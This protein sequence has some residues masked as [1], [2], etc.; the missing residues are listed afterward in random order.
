V[1]ENDA[2]FGIL[3]GGCLL[4]GAPSGLAA[5]QASHRLPYNRSEPSIGL[6]TH[7]VSED[8][9]LKRRE[10]IY[11]CK[12]FIAPCRLTVGQAIARD[13]AVNIISD[14]IRRQGYPCDEPRH[15][16]HDAQASRP[17]EA[18]W[19]LRCQGATYRVTLVPDKA[20]RVEV[21]E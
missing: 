4:S 12:P 5:S 18:V 6:T 16:E 19:I 2:I 13:T 9:G 21:V 7:V 8:G 3:L 17:H 1:T 10:A 14:H 20:A 15:A 11:P